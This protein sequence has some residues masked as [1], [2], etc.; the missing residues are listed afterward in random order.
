MSLHS[1]TY[2]ELSDEEVD[3]VSE[4]LD[5]IEKSGGEERLEVGDVE[6]LITEGLPGEYENELPLVVKDDIDSSLDSDF[7]NILASKDYAVNVYSVNFEELSDG[8]LVATTS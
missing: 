7:S 2:W 1:N 8:S 5:K 4:A 3:E 6:V